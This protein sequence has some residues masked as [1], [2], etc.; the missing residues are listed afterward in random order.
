MSIPTNRAKSNR[1]HERL[2][3]RNCCFLQG[4]AMNLC[5]EYFKPAQLL[6]VGPLND[7]PF[8]S[9]AIHLEQ[10]KTAFNTLEPLLK[11]SHSNRG[12]KWL[13]LLRTVDARGARAAF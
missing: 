11:R 3:I 1:F 2:K 12:G 4:I 8:G 9:L 6:C 13:R 7:F 5:H 10:I